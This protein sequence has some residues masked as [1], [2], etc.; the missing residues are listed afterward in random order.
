MFSFVS[1]FD[2]GVQD[3]FVVLTYL[4]Y[5][6]NIIS[7]PDVLETFV[8]SID[9]IQCNYGYVFLM[10]LPFFLN[11]E[12]RVKV[13]IGADPQSPEALEYA[14]FCLRSAYHALL[15]ATA[16]NITIQTQVKKALMHFDGHPAS[17][18]LSFCFIWFCCETSKVR[19]FM[20]YLHDTF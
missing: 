20:E 11:L 6:D 10:F 14:H 16:K 8:G 1:I 19:K 12:P 2:R 9:V 13:E 3:W 17:N 18:F 5:I 4:N 15:G 7:T